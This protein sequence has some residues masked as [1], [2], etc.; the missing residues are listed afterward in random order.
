M[1]TGMVPWV[2]TVICHCHLG[3]IHWYRT[4]TALAFCGGWGAGEEGVACHQPAGC[5]WLTQLHPGAGLYSGAQG[6]RS[7]R[8]VSIP[9]FLDSCYSTGD[10][11][12]HLQRRHKFLTLGHIMLPCEA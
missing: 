3:V 7:L 5:C 11:L 10:F 1:P 8:S 12:R 4:S 2:F 6:R 9:S